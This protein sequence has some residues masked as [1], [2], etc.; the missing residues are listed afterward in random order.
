[1]YKY[2]LGQQE[3]IISWKFV[4][5]PVFSAPSKLNVKEKKKICVIVDKLLEMFSISTENSVK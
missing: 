2:Y 4:V 5:N 1:M 3:R